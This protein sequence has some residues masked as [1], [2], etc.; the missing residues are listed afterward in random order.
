MSDSSR[1]DVLAVAKLPPFYLQPLQAAFTLHDRLHETDPQ[2]FAKI[3][4]RIRAITGGGESLVSRELMQQLPALEMISIMGVGYDKVDVR[5]AIERGIPVTHTPEVLNDEVADL[6]LALML[7][8]ARRVPQADRHV[9]ENRWAEQGPMPLA[10]KVSGK[11]LGIVGLGRIG[12]AIAQRAQGFG[13]S[14]AYTGR[15]QQ[16]GVSFPYYPT[17]KALA[18]N[19]EF[20][21]V[22]TPGGE[23][24]R[25]MINAEVLQA[26]GPKGF[27]INVA[28]GTVVDEAALV[29]ALQRGVI[30]GAGLDVFE[31]E[32]RVPEALRALGNVVL[33]PHMASATHETRQAMAD[34]ALANLQAH[35][36]GQPLLS[37]VPE[38]R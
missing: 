15:T 27:L 31:D 30:A 26:L 34:L 37:P 19:V 9:R 35:F 22:I 28:R 10:T 12:K 23:G 7:S 29:D 4:P 32:P 25:R 36:A 21:V 18:A 20:L 8:V 24:T 16:A 14:I 11:R 17:A 1:P 6:A 2:A 13:M 38:C 5:A 3:A 33:T